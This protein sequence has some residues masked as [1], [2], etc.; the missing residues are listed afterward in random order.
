M[1]KDLMKMV[2]ELT[3]KL[4]T[5]ETGEIIRPAY[6]PEDQFVQWK[7][8]VL[9]TPQIQAEMKDCHPLY[10]KHKLDGECRK[11]GITV[12]EYFGEQARRNMEARRQLHVEG[13]SVDYAKHRKEF[14]ANLPDME[15]AMTLRTDMALAQLANGSNPLNFGCVR[16]EPLK[17]DETPFTDEE[18]AKRLD[19]P[20]PFDNIVK[21]SSKNETD[22]AVGGHGIIT[23][24]KH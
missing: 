12:E 16:Y 1:D 21:P 23:T 8:V 5:T 4:N 3:P 14:L 24:I 17:E 22:I 19:K 2:V 10:V 15:M 18:L 11:H 13:E 6:V 9:A 7:L 20:H